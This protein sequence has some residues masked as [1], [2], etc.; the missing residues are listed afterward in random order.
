MPKGRELTFT[1]V[2]NGNDT[3]TLSYVA[4]VCKH[5]SHHTDGKCDVCSEIVKH[6]F[7]NGALH[8]VHS[9]L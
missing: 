2:N 9:P 7:Y 1:L 8:T 3:F 4:A 6:N 5:E